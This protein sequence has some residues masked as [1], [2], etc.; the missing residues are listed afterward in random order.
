[1][2]RRFSAT[3][4]RLEL[5]PTYTQ[6]ILDMVAESP[7]DD[8]KHISD[9]VLLLHRLTQSAMDK[10]VIEGPEEKALT[11]LAITYGVLR[12]LG[13]S[14]VRVEECLKAI[15]GTGLE[16]AYEWVREFLPLTDHEVEYLS[17]S[18]I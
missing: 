1:V 17:F 6:K 7:D 12:R 15:R 13:F 5:D 2:D 10:S 11:K 8:S 18:S 9:P 16:E 3:L 4:S 14:E